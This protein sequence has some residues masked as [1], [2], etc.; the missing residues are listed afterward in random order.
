MSIGLID[1]IPVSSGGKVE[2]RSAELPPE[3]GIVRGVELG[4]AH[5][6]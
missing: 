5:N 2:N 6:P 1:E 4:A 3:E